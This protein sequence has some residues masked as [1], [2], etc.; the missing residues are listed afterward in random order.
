MTAL[1]QLAN[2]AVA[3]D[4]RAMQTVLKLILLL[5]PDEQDRILKVIIEG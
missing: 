3:G 1:T 5:P 4:I 2:K